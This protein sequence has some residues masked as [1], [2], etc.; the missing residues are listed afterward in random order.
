MG[1]AATQ[2]EI[3]QFAT[4]DSGREIIGK[5][6]VAAGYCEVSAC[7]VYGD[8]PETYTTPNIRHGLVEVLQEPNNESSPYVTVVSGIA[9]LVII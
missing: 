8:L 2:N 9:W 3:V 1:G 4:A 6:D 5:Q 7:Y